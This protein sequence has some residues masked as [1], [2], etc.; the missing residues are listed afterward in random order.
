MRL[1]EFSHPGNKQY[2]IPYSL[3]INV[4]L[5]SE[6]M[7]LI[8]EPRKK[9]YLFLHLCSSFFF[10]SGVWRVELVQIIEVIGKTKMK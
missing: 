1:L 3:T 4:F 7:V 5:P 9:N 8:H 10:S 2:N 6:N